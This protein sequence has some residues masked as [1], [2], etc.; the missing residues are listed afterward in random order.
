MDK[1]KGAYFEGSISHSIQPKDQPFS[2]VLGALAGL[3]AGQGIPDDPHS[4]QSFNFA[5]NGFTHL[6]FPPAFPLPRGRS[7]FRRRCTS[8]SPATMPPSSPS[9]PTR[10]LNSKDVKVW[11]GGTIS[12]SKALGEAP[13]EEGASSFPASP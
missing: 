8:S 12:W 1:I 2:V 4:D 11:F 5:D 3:S 7:R 13:A 6:D 10:E 9:R